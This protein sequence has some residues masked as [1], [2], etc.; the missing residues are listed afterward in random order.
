MKRRAWLLGTTAG[1]GALLVGWLALPQRSR[2][3]LA[4]LMAPGEGDFALNGWIKILPD[5]GVV[6]AMPR[7]EMGQGV[8]TAL[9]QLAAEE[10]DVPL[11][12]VRLEQAG[13]DA[14]Y[15]NVAMLYGYLPF[16]PRE[17]EREDGFGRVKAGRWLVGKVGRELGLN[18]T[19]GSSSVAD[20]W[21]TV[22]LAA[23]TARASL[24]G[25]ASL[26]WKLPTEEFQVSD[27]VVSHPSGRRAGYGELAREA[28]S[29]PPGQVQLK[30]RKQWR[31]IG[32]PAPRLDLAS[33]VNGQARFGIDVRLPGMRYA[34]LRLAPS[35]GGAPGRIDAAEA[36][37]LPGVERLV[38][39]PAYAGSSAGFAV[40]ASSFWQAQRA[41]Q[42]VEV[43]WRAGPGG[44]PDS[45]AIARRLEEA[46]R[47]R[48]GFTFYSEGNVEAVAAGEGSR[49]IEAWYRAPYLA[50][51]TLEPMNATARVEGGRVEVWAPTQVPQSCREAAARVA[52][53]PVE[54]VELHVTYLGGGFGRR[55][56]VDYVAQAVRVAMDLPGVPVQLIWPREE[57][58]THDFY[59]PAQVARLRATLDRQGQPLA[60]QIRSAGDAIAPRWMERAAPG[61]AGPIDLPD[62]TGA[63]GLFDQPYAFAHQR[64]QHVFTRS[65][66]PV[67]F[68]RSVGHSHNAFF[69]ESFI[70]EIAAQLR[71]DPLVLRRNL[72]RDSPRHLA[73]LNLAAERSGWERVPLP[74]GRARGLALH[75]SFGSVVAQVVE[76]SLQGPLPRVHRVVCAIDCGTVV[77]PQIVAQQMEGAVVFA[78]SAALHG[79]VDIRRGVVQQR[80]F[81][82]YP[83]LRL[84]LAPQVET[85]IVPSARAPSGVGEPGVP[86]LAPALAGALFALTGQRHRSLPLT[87]LS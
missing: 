40:V 85:Y 87:D 84:A 83:M 66:V 54:R 44:G 22:R 18:A 50:H 53:V 55:L 35:L 33:K 56:E 16:H 28:A 78:L 11:S 15:G 80:N 30:E 9:P 70:D 14:I 20:A 79:R 3:G 4:R 81:P 67:G 19:G 69:L 68:W 42:A 73:V 43:E 38:Q 36:L 59:R 41:A 82:D 12:A 23:A 25:A 64:I 39:L 13:W 45:A 10:L 86:P 21:D 34:A 60:L 52:G 46:V 61:L 8:H 26:R 17:E 47:S 72:L 7:S 49:T 48:E 58:T 57:D 5:G 77:N 2:I 24:L 31:V 51:A 6:L 74:A 32:R 62:K 75:E 27:G 65:G 29:T 1:M 71:Q 76:V 37:A 63:E